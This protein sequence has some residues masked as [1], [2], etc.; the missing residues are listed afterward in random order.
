MGSR[1]R[2]KK[3][4]NGTSLYLDNCY[5]GSRSYEFLGITLRPGNSPADR[6]H[7]REMLNLAERI[8]SKRWNEILNQT[9]GVN[10]KLNGQKDFLG[11]AETII[12]ERKGFN[13]GH[14][15]VL[16]KL[17][18]FVGKNALLPE[19]INER[20]LDRFYDF[21]ETCLTGESPSCY[22]KKLKRLLRE[23]TKE[24]MFVTNP[25]DLVRCRKFTT[26]QKEILT[27]D[28]MNILLHAKCPNE[29]VK[30]AFL[31]SCLTGLRYCDMKELKACS[32][33]G[34]K[35]ELIQKKTKVKVS[36]I[37][38][39][40]AIKLIPKTAKNE[41]LIFHLPS[42]NG[43]L[44][45]LRVWMLNA[46]IEKHITWHGARHSFGSNLVF[47]GADIYTTSKLLGHT[48]LK[49]TERYLR[50]SCKLKE[51]AV[52]NLPRLF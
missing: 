2:K 30:K 14:T 24:K 47:N 10:V 48:S 45:N 4:K 12:M 40:D 1:I 34:N 20:F 3:G 29:E 39:D 37:L 50:E 7:N 42:H 25:A 38:N 6:E 41:D 15:G 28:E 27:F 5:K 19:A 13:R 51:Q 22:F 11:F 23:A 21:L 26:K 33:K 36:V 44:K 17:K 43:C 46:N 16:N 31:F 8:R 52:N 35:L 18:L 32:I 9:H 49:H